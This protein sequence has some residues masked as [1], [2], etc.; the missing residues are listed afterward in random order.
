VVKLALSACASFFSR[1]GKPNKKA[2]GN[3]GFFVNAQA[4]EKC[5]LGLRFG[6][7]GRHRSHF[8]AVGA[9]DAR[10]FALQIAQ[11]I[12]PCPAN[13]TLATTSIE[14]IVG[15]CSGKMRSMP[16]PKLTR[17]TVNVALDARPFL[18]ITH[19][20]EGLE[21]LLHLL[22]F[23][24]LQADVDAHGVARAELG[25]VFAQLRFM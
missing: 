15:E 19:A 14:L 21:A 10:G 8:L 1:K 23:A 24:F 13:F 20:L 4:I 22:A 18:E 12:Q 16:T 6:T 17:R 25:E 3:R 9:L 2:P 5:H 11:V 7:G